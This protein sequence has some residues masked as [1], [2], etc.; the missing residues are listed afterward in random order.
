ME[1]GLST[2]VDIA[3]TPAFLSTCLIGCTNHDRILNSMKE[4]MYHL[5]PHSGLNAGVDVPSTPAVRTK[6]K[7]SCNCFEKVNRGLLNTPWSQA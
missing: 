3:S 7:R 4:P 1:S 2:G 5:L 6:F